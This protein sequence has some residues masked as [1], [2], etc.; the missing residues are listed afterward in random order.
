MLLLDKQKQFAEKMDANLFESIL[1]TQDDNAGRKFQWKSCTELAEYGL[2]INE[3]RELVAMVT[4]DTDLSQKV[5]IYPGADEVGL[6]MLGKISGSN[7][8]EGRRNERGLHGKVTEISSYLQ[9]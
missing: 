9:R 8:D 1:I 6:T 2:N 7:T 3:A 4:A 5:K